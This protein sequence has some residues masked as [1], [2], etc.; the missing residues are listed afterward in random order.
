MGIAREACG[1]ACLRMITTDIYMSKTT[2]HSAAL[3]QIIEALTP[4]KDHDAKM[5]VSTVLTLLEIAAHQEEGV[6][7]HPL[8]LQ[9][10]IGYQSGTAT[11]NIYYWCEGHKD[12]RGGHNY[13]RV[14]ADKTDGRRREL[15]LTDK[16][17]AFMQ[18]VLTPLC[19]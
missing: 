3:R 19:E 10:K 18:R 5:Q 6:K 2:Q 1:C 17:A 15:Y 4:F 16:G 8:S 7:I 12:V 9:K 11:R 13:A 14:E